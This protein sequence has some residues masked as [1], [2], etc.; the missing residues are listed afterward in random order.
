MKDFSQK[1][2]I[3]LTLK[4]VSESA[5]VFKWNSTVVKKFALRDEQK[6]SAPTQYITPNKWPYANRPNELPFGNE[7]KCIQN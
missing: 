4:F 2:R 1:L 5:L 6:F 7:D 3:K